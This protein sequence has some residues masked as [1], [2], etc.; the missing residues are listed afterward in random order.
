[1]IVSMHMFCFTD[2]VFSELTKYKY[3]WSMIICICINMVVNLAVFLRVVTRIA[4]L[5]GLKYAKRFD[6]K[7][8]QYEWY[9]RTKESMVV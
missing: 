3:G 2:A 9:K 7:M 5:I 8:G 4:Y 1:M 6:R